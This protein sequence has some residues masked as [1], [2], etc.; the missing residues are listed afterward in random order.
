MISTQKFALALLL[1]GFFVTSAHADFPDD[2]DDVV[3]IEEGFAPGITEYVRAMR[4]T[5]SSSVNVAGGNVIM[6]NT[7]STV[8]PLFGLADIN[9]NAWLIVKVE[10][11]WYAGTFEFMR[12]GQTT[13][14]VVAL[15][16]VG[17]LRFP[18]LSR[19]LPKNGEVYGF[20]LSGVV[21]NGIR[22]GKNN[23]QERTDISFF[24]WGSGPI[25]FE[26]AFPG[27]N[28]TIAPVFNLLQDVPI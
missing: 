18:P 6:T 8:W 4:V 19:F 12:K 20:M 13:K 16:G 28:P 10:D 5:A 14:K 2:L 24:K 21:R 22:P 25:A 7:R 26:D 11:T 17:H 3:F 27:S 9:A 23:I 15:N 1:L